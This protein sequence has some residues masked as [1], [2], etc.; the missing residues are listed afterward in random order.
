[1]ITL[2][3]VKILIAIINIKLLIRLFAVGVKRR[4]A[5]EDRDQRAAES[6]VGRQRV[7]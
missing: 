2:T 1:M 3:N 5:P 4:L 6:E 7:L